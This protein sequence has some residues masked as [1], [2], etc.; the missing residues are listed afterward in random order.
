MTCSWI[1]HA[2]LKP[3]SCLAYAWLM[4]C[5][6][7]DHDL[8]LTCSWLALD[9]L[10]TCS[11]LAHA[12]LM[13]RSCLAH[14]MLMTWSW[15]ALDLL[16]TCSWLTHDLLMTFSWVTNWLA[17]WLVDL[18][19]DWLDNWLTDLLTNWLIDCNWLDSQHLSWNSSIVLIGHGLCRFGPCLKTDWSYTFLKVKNWNQNFT[20]KKSIEMLEIWTFMGKKWPLCTL[21]RILN[22]FLDIFE[23]TVENKTKLFRENCFENVVSDVNKK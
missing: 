3:C 7:L 15:L 16:L 13:P 20:L 5:S 10:M 8:L 9:L 1:A 19:T 22:M 18:L 23:F 2:L 6:W 11:C 12:L 21:W 14:A 4:P 17:D